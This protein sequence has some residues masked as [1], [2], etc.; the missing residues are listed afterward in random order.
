VSRTGTQTAVA[1]TQEMAARRSRGSRTSGWRGLLGFKGA[2]LLP[3]V[4]FLVVFAAYPLFELVRMAFSTVDVRGGAFTWQFSGLANLARVPEDGVFATALRNTVVF[5]A[6][7]TVST[8]LLGAGLA[9]LVDR[10]RLLGRVARNVFLWPAVIAPVVVSVIWWMLLSPEFGL[11]NRL[12]PLIGL[13]PQ[14]WLADPDAA[15]PAVMLVD[16]WH[17]TPIVFLLVYAALQAVDRN[18]YEAARID[19]ASEWQIVRRLTLPLLMPTVLAAAGVRVVMGVKVFDEMFLL[20]H[21]GPG[22]A[23]TIVSIHIQKVFFDDVDLGYGAALGLTVV[24]AVLAVVGG[25]A[26]GRRALGRTREVT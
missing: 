10:A 8:V 5:V 11:L 7:T 22:V 23:T 15:L 24:A 13:Q 14:G 1:A 19:G 18:L 4:L 20:T 3:L 6:G 2:A 9:L 26:L 16:V 12:L 17:W 25:G 21:G